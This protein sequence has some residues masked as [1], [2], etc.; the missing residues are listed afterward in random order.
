MGVGRRSGQRTVDLG[1]RRWGR[2]LLEDFTAADRWVVCHGLEARIGAA[3]M[4]SRC[5][6]IGR[7]L[8]VGCDFWSA[9]HRFGLP[10]ELLGEMVEHR[11]LVLRRP[12]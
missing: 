3:L 12:M 8:L 6:S 4:P 5:C 10:W 9:G 2:S 1:R 11:I 7:C